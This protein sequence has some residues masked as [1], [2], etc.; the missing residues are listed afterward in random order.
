MVS[1]Y[2]ML[3]DD[4]RFEQDGALTFHWNPIF[5]GLRPEK[6]SYAQSSL[7]QVILKEMENNGWVGVCCEPNL[8]FVVCNQFPVSGIKRA[9]QQPLNHRL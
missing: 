7:Q 4:D 9:D 2:S 6:F 5:F 3:F 8:V 1:L